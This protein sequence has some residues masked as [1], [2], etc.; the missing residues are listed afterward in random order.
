MNTMN[1]PR[2]VVSAIFSNAESPKPD[3]RRVNSSVNRITRDDIIGPM[4]MSPCEKDEAFFTASP[5]PPIFEE[6][7]DN[8]ENMFQFQEEIEQISGNR[9]TLTSEKTLTPT[10]DV[11]SGYDIKTCFHNTVSG[12]IWFKALDDSGNVYYYSLDE[13]VSVWELPKVQKEESE[14]YEKTRKSSFSQKPPRPL[15]KPPTMITK[16]LQTSASI[17]DTPRLSRPGSLSRSNSVGWADFLKDKLSTFFTGR[18]KR[19]ELIKRGIIKSPN[20]FGSTLQTIA[21]SEQ[22]PIPKFVRK[23]I[24]A[25]ESDPDNLE[26]T[27]LYRQAGVHS[28]VQKIRYE[29][30]Q[31]NYT[32]LETEESLHVLTG[33]LKLFFRELREPLIPWNVVEKLQPIM[34]LPNTEAKLESMKEFLKRMP[35]THY[36][37][38][39]C[40]LRHMA[41]VAS[42]KS[43]NQMSESNLGIVLGPTLMWSPDPTLATNMAQNMVQ[44]GLIVETLIENIN[45]IDFTRVK[46]I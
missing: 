2:R 37:T 20:T 6:C 11:P 19:D 30:E 4:S 14:T 43:M 10:E 32:V 26:T 46:I 39:F 22:S 24:A 18:P 38:L 40:L 17:S 1:R 15:T 9:R 45:N 44:Q 31:G 8:N 7:E 3:V 34:K 27:G 16:S 28:A 42:Y 41:K 36:D 29:I 35:S 12:E 25:I 23:C 21:D 33:A 13:T 5:T